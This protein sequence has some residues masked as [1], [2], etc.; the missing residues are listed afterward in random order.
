MNLEAFIK[1][2]LAQGTVG[3]HQG[4]FAGQCVSLI[5]QYCWLV[6]GVPADAWGDAKD[7]ADPN[8]ANVTKYFEHVGTLQSGDILVYPGAAINGWAGHIE[9]YISNGQAL[10][11]NRNLDGRIGIGLV[12]PGYTAIRK[13]GTRSAGGNVED[14]PTTYEVANLYS[15]VIM[16]Q[17]LSKDDW[18]KYHKNKT[19]N[20]LFDEF[21]QSEAR[22]EKLNV[23][24]GAAAAANQATT[25]ANIRYS[26]ID[27]I[28]KA[29]GVQRQPDE[30]AT[31]DTAIKKIASLSPSESESSRK[32]N[33]VK[34]IVND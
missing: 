23:L 34:K 15:Q 30:M 9:I 24:L 22:R 12:L 8:N 19:R 3:K 17:D 20:Q 33:E 31:V 13:K 10:Y 7:W 6:L 2:A 11:Q 29:L 26:Q 28:L 14:Q 25:I 1:W 5:N 21:Y 32:I 18:E 4:G 27:N 16:L